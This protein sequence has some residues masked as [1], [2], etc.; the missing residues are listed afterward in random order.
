MVLRV[1]YILA[2]KL[3]ARTFVL[4]AFLVSVVVSL[5]DFA[6]V[7]ASVGHMAPTFLPVLSLGGCS[8]PPIEDV[9][10]IFLPYL[11][12]QTILFA[13]TL[14]PSFRSRRRSRSSQITRR[15][16]RE[17]VASNLSRMHTLTAKFSGSI[18]YFAFFGAI[19]PSRQKSA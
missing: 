1:W 12:A 10:K 17:W 2:G 8:A 7:F 9:W 18:F 5:K 16:V 15:L 14:W 6:T 19:A 4:S 3:Y 11:V 13:S